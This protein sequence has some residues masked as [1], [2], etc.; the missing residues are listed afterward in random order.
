MKKILLLC[1]IFSFINCTNKKKSNDIVAWLLLYLNSEANH[2]LY[3]YI[4]DPL[5]QSTSSTAQF[6]VSSIATKSSKTKVVL[7]HGWDYS[8]RS[9]DLPSSLDKK[10]AQITSTWSSALNYYNKDT[11]ASRTNFDFYAFTYRTS[12]SISKNGA[13][14]AEKLNTTFTASDKVIVVASSMGGLV[15]R[16][17]MYDAKNTGDVI[18]YAV[19]LGTPHYGS[20]FASS[21]YQVSSATLAETISFLTNTDGGRGLSHTNKGDGQTSITNASNAELDSLNANTSRD[22]RFYPYVGD[23]SSD[24]NA[25][26]TSAVLIAGCSVLK[27]GTPA[28]TATDGIVPINSA[29]MAN[30]VSATQVTTKTGFDH[31]MLT[32]KIASDSTLSETFFTEVMTKIKT[33]TF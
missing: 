32:F 25:A 17:A 13:R 29:K 24:C 27:S 5:Q 16:Y 10:V 7:I 28:F 12:D 14:L 30:K 9:S 26:K 8:E 2:E 4:E 19:T 18:D 11:A 22:S 33:F 15:T 21:A 31:L 6:V 3:K 23:L 20:P 1:L